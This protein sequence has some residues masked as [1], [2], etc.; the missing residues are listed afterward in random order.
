MTAGSDT[1]RVGATG[2]APGKIILLGEHAVVYGRPAIAVPVTRLQATA[3]VV[4]LPA[5]TG[6]WIR[7]VDLGRYYRLHQ[8]PADDPLAHAV[9][10]AWRAFGNSGEPDL[11]IVIHST[12]PIAGGLGSG[13]AVATAVVRALAVYLGRSV[14]PEEVSALVYETEKL[15]HGTP[16]GIDNTVVA[17]ERPIWF[18][19]GTPPE[20]FEPGTCFHLLI[21]DTGVSSP[22]RDTVAAVRAAWQAEPD[23]YETLFDRIGTLVARG[24][25]AMM[26]G[27]PARLGTLLDENQELLRQ[28]GVSSPEIE[29]LLGP[30]KSAGALGAKLSG[31]GRGGNIIVLVEPARLEAV[32]R[33]MQQAGAVRVVE[34]VLAPSSRRDQSS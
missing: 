10:I 31:G 4:P 29:Q 18:R 9:R 16:S 23:H 22:T 11:E 2:T 20:P 1:K 5:G 6:T 26:S 19:R 30:A 14:S 3:H 8:A 17:Y 25:A 24:R 32:R 12:I 33:A 27:S 15:L 21:A 7:A 13:A 34:T 28:L